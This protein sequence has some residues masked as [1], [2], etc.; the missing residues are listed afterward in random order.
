[1]L[2]TADHIAAIFEV[3]KYITVDKFSMLWLLP[4]TASISIIYK[5]TKIPE[6]KV[7]PFIKEVFLLFLSIIIFMAFTALILYGL[8]MFLIE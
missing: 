3:P 5:T 8:Q 4:L 6:I 1:M 2:I 7:L